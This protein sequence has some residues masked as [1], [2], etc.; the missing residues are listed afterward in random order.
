MGATIPASNPYRIPCIDP[1]WGEA[2]EAIDLFPQ[3]Q[4]QKSIITAIPGF[5]E[6]QTYRVDCDAQEIYLQLN[7]A[8][9]WNFVRNWLYK[10]KFEPKHKMPPFGTNP[11]TKASD[12][13]RGTK[14]LGELLHSVLELCKECHFFPSSHSRK[15]SNAGLWFI[16]ATNEIRTICLGIERGTNKLKKVEKL[17]NHSKT[18]RENCNPFGEIEFPHL[19][20]LMA[21]AT[22]LAADT[23]NGQHFTKEYL[24]RRTGRKGF[25]TALSA[26][27]TEL[28]SNQAF[29][30]VDANDSGLSYSAGR[31]Q[32][33][34]R[35]P[36]IV[37]E[38]RVTAILSQ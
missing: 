33:R 4:W 18:L 29:K 19:H 7:E 17:R 9:V 14:V 28:Q 5:A 8:T 35:V 22:Q 37:V 16:G 24:M 27:A 26:W 30:I 12:V 21:V 3:I 31:G 11:G 20:S 15:Y 25:I 6:T 34:I 2:L 32:G 23:K 1:P 13:K 36:K 10:L 38:K